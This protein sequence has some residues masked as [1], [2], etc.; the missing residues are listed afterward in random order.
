MT[1]CFRRSGMRKVLVI[2]ALAAALFTA[3][4]YAID[5]EQVGR[6][7]TT[8][9]VL[10]DALVARPLGLVGTIIGAATW[11]V[12]L[13]FTLPSE[14]STRAAD[15]LVRKPARYTFLRP[16]GQMDGCDALPQSCKGKTSAADAQMAEGNAGA[17]TAIVSGTGTTSKLGRQ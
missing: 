9:E 11:V 15:A 10:A 13:P 4:A 12:S 16:I 3:P 5:Q 14:S 1:I 17:P 7:P 2:P 8:N 6:E